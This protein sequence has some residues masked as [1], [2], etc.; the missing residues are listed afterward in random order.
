MAASTLDE[1]YYTTREAAEYL[2]LHEK[3]IRK[4]ALKGE[5]RHERL[6]GRLRFRRTWLDAYARSWRGPDGG[7]GTW[8]RGGSGS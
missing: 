1:R 3:T 8:G 6:G 2:V 7:E 4:K 5:I